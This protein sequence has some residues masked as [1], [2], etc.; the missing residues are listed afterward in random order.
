[1]ECQKHDDYQESITWLLD[2]IDEYAGHGRGLAG[3]GQEHVKSVANVWSSN[4]L[5]LRVF[6]DTFHCRIRNSA[7]L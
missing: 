7:S 3:N 2:Y 5:S 4:L 1:M 6:S